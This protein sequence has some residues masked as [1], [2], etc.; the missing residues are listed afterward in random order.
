MFEAPFYTARRP[1]VNFAAAMARRDLTVGFI[2][3]SITDQRSR[4]RWADMLTY[5]L[6]S[7]HPE[8]SLHIVNAAIG[9]TDSLHAL[10]RAEQDLADRGCDIIFIE[11]AV[12]DLGMPPERRARVREGLVRKLWRS[13]CDLVFVYTYERSMLADMLAERLPDSIADFETLAAHY[14][15]PG[16]FSGCYALDCVRRGRLRYEEWLPDGLHPEHCGSRFYA[17]PVLALLNAELTRT[18]GM[19]AGENAAVLPAP[20][21]SD[22]GEKAY[23]LPFSR[24]ERSGY[25]FEQQPLVLP[26]VRRTLSSFAPGSSLAFEFEGSGFVIMQDF[27]QCAGDFDYRIDG[28]AWQ[29]SGIA[30]EAWIQSGWGVMRYV[31]QDDLAPGTH[32]VELA[33]CLRP[34]SDAKGCNLDICYVGIFP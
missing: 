13:G 7:A 6:C 1:L 11:F 9:A 20:L 27:G 31:V 2:G 34:E 17:D 19:T 14:G 33:L 30:Q 21:R 25:W 26:L 28:G 23:C 22:N 12:N 3:G 18:A 24:I 29:R 4:N 16:V 10:F 15:I 8:V 32:R 5:E